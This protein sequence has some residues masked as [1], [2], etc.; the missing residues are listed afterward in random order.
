MRGFGN[1]GRRF[2]PGMSAE[3]AFPHFSRAGV[4]ERHF[5][6][7]T[8]IEIDRPIGWR[9]SRFTPSFENRFSEKAHELKKTTPQEG[10][11]CG[12]TGRGPAQF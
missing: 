1:H 10:R 11:V 5:K 9:G 8:A 12:K 4:T 3:Q 2:D 6:M 7:A